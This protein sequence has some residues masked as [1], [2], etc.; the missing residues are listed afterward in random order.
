MTVKSTEEIPT[1]PNTTIRNFDYVVVDG[2]KYVLAAFMENG[3][4]LRLS[5]YA[6]KP[7]TELHRDS[8]SVATI[9]FKLAALTASPMAR[10]PDL[11][12]ILTASLMREVDPNRPQY[13]Q[14]MIH[15]DDIQSYKESKNADA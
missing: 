11:M 7:A 3:D 6:I 13:R 12:V 9:D 5:M 2:S 14:L 8:A 10:S 1:R 4:K 15:S